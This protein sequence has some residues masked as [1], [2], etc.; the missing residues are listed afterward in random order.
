MRKNFWRGGAAIGALAA[1]FVGAPPAMADSGVTVILGGF[2][3]SEG[4]YRSRDEQADIGSSFSGVPFS[5]A[6]TAHTSETRFTARQSRLSLL[7]SGDFDSDTHFTLW[8]EF[9]FLGGAQ[10]ANSNESNSYNLRIRNIYATVDWD[11]LGLE[12]LAGQNWSLLTLNSH[13]ITP[14]NEVTPATIDAQYS[15]GF[16]WARQPQLRV[17]KSWNREFWLALSVENPQTTFAANAAAAAGISVTNLA[18]G[19]SE[20]DKANNFSLNHIP[21]LIGKIAWEPRIGDAQPLHIEAFGIYRSY[22]DRINVAATNALGLPPAIHNSNQSGGG[23]GGSIAWSILPGLLDLQGTLMT[24]SGI[25]RYGSGQ[26]A[27][28][29]F[30][31][32]GSLAPIQETTGLLGATLHVTPKLDVYTYLGQEEEQAKYFNIGTAHLG[33]GNPNY[34]LAGCFV[35]G[36]SCSPNVEAERQANVGFWWRPWQAKFGNFRLGMQYSY[37]RL[38]AFAGA[39]GKPTTDDSMVFTSVRFYPAF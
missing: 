33:L 6:S 14:R 23:V 22:Y 20:F 35:E 29:T 36:G 9:D 25:G 18:A 28:V 34:N 1:T 37:T 3:A 32:D 24:G 13:G 17:T 30:R 2:L 16:N 15:V 31:P 10:T 38:T 4:V 26:L 8:N 5:N 19:G 27:D 21:D 12:V 39:G 7:V 11:S